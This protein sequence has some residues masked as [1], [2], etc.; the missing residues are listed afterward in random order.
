MSKI[1]V[2][3][4]LISVSTVYANFVENELPDVI[5]PVSYNLKISPDLSTFTFYGKVDIEV[6]VKFST[7]VIKLHCKSLEISKS[8]LYD[9]ILPDT[10]ISIRLNKTDNFCETTSLQML[11]PGSI[12]VLSME[13]KGDLKENTNGLYRTSYETNGVKK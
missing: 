10:L 8:K 1:F 2:L 11:T 12:Y 9:K 5:E 6:R 7:D 4:A 13:F 3:L